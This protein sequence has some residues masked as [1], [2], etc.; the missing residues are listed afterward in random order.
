MVFIIFFY[1]ICFVSLLFY[2]LLV[3]NLSQPYVLDDNSDWKKIETSDFQ[4]SLL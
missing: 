4:L 3:I 2:L 1:L